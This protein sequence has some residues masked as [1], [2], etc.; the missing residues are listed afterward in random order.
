M[1]DLKLNH[2]LTRVNLAIRNINKGASKS[3][4]LIL[5]DLQKL[6]KEDLK[7]CEIYSRYLQR[8]RR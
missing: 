7:R 4:L 8:G 3:G 6:I 1:P 5:K 2:I